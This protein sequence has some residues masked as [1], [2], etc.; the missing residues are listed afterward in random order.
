[1][2][3]GYQRLDILVATP[4]RLVSLHAQGFVALHTVER[5]VIDEADRLF[6]LG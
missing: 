3:G 4:M 1:M 2:T 5:L 6:D